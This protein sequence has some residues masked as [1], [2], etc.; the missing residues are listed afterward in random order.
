MLRGN[1]LQTD[2]YATVTASGLADGDVVQ[3]VEDTT[4]LWGGYTYLHCAAEDGVKEAVRALAEAANGSIDAKNNLQRTALH[5]AALN[6]HAEVAED[7][8]GVAADSHAVDSI[9]ETP[10]HYAAEYGH[11]AA[12]RALECSGADVDAAYKPGNRPL[13]LAASNDKSGAACELLESGAAI[14]IVKKY[15]QNLRETLQMA[16]AEAV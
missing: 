4:A 15:N 3:L 1:P 8:V 9:G 10:L 6:G 2:A 11:E 5:L 13:H 16:G 14:I 7:L 12:M